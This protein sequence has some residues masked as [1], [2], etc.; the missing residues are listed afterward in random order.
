[1]PETEPRVEPKSPSSMDQVTDSGL[2][3]AFEQ[4]VVTVSSHAIIDY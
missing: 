1:M 3:D 2:Y 4:M